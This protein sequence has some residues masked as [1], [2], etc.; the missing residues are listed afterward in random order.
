MNTTYTFDNYI[1]GRN[2]DIAF[3]ICKRVAENPGVSEQN[4]LFIYGRQG[5]ERLTW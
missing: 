3:S 1:N 5:L 4:P 2:T